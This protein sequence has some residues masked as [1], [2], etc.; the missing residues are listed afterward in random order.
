M[1][2]RLQRLACIPRQKNVDRVGEEAGASE[3]GTKGGMEGGSEW[4]ERGAG[5]VGRT[6]GEGVSE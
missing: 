3:Q 5:W 4:S 6:V 2:S 1:L